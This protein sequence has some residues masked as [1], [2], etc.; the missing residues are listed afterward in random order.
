MLRHVNLLLE[1]L[2]GKGEEVLELKTTKLRAAFL[3]PH[4]PPEAFA[5]LELLL[6]RKWG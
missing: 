5:F 3:Q 2:Q 4:K 6:G 1:P